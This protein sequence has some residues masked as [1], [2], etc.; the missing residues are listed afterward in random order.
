MGVSDYKIKLADKTGAEYTYYIDPTTYYISKLD[1]KASVAGKDISNSSSF[2]NY[3]KTDF[4]YVI[5]NT[6]ATSN[7]GYDIVIN[8]NKIE[9]NKTID[10][11]IFAMPK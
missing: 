2:S 1:V 7:M 3:K 9:I 5:A 6:T 10:P 4:G 11:S 8:Y